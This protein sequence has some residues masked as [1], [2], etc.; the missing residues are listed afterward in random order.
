M[1]ILTLPVAPRFNSCRFGLRGNTL[2][3]VSPLT[4]SVQVLEFTGAYAASTGAPAGPMLWT[5]FGLF[6]LGTTYLFY[7][8]ERK[9][10]TPPVLLMEARWVAFLDR[11]VAVFRPKR[12][13]SGTR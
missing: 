12:A 7:I 5:A 8:T 9:A 3:H 11:I 1:S 13:A 6:A 4:K 10:G 2:E